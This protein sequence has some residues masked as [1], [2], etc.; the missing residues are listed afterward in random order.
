MGPSLELWFANMLCTLQRLVAQ[1]ASVCPR[2]GLRIMLASLM[3]AALSWQAAAETTNPAVASVTEPPT[4]PPQRG[5]VTLM[6][7]LRAS[8]SVQSEIVA[9]AKEGTHVDILVE[10]ERWYRVRNSE[11]VEAWIYKPLVL[12][13]RK[14]SKDASAP[15]LALAPADSQEIP[16]PLAANGE[17][18]RSEGSAA[19]PPD[20][21]PEPPASVAALPALLDQ[22]GDSAEILGST[23]FVDALLLRVPGLGAYL[24]IGLVAVLA[25]AIAFQLRAARQLRRAMQEMG[26]ILNIVEE[27]Y[28]G[29]ALAPQ[30]DR[31]AA[32]MPTPA[33]AL[34]HQPP[35]PGLEFSVIEQAVLEALS[36][37]DLVQEGVLAKMLDEQGF[38]CLLIKAV[39]GD[40]MRKTSTPGLEWVE[41]RYAQGRYSYRLR[42]EAVSNLGEQL[43]H[44]RGGRQG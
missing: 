41:V 12:I 39:I 26:Q 2:T 1:S 4:A 32:G 37:Q 21:I 38:G 31:V 6:S 44:S 13:D 33:E 34:G 10:T 25:L 30:G 40:I 15:V 27:I 3:V 43:A 8:P 11:G 17:A 20:R 5:L 16:S 7:N 19:S 23:R 35:A 36:D 24:I 18:A 42:P 14:P 29:G 28:T 22:R 9:I